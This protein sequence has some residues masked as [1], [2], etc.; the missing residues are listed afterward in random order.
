V[1]PHENEMT[2]PKELAA[3]SESVIG[4][5]RRRSE[6]LTFEVIGTRLLATDYDSLVADLIESWKNGEPRTLSFCNTYMVTKRRIDAG[7]RDTARACDTNLPDGMPLVWCMNLQGARLDDR[8]YGPIFMDRFLKASPAE[9]RHYFLGGSQKCLDALCANARALNPKLQLVGAHH[10]YFSSDKEPGV[11]ANIRAHDPDFIWVGLGTPKQDE[12]VAR[13]RKVFPRAILLPVGS[14]FEFLA[15]DKPAPP[16]R[17]QRLGLTWLFRLASEPRRLGPR[18]FKYN[19]LF[20]YYLVRDW[21]FPPAT[22][23]P[24]G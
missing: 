18:Y 1:A 22:A 20:L 2:A 15:G 10:G 23:R 6:S 7:Y 19:I 11:L 24:A 17:L 9:I 21:L 3:G 14:S 4:T 13:H 8:V 12:W 5:A 16:L